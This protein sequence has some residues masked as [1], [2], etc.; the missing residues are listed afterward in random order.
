M[1][2]EAAL[3]S[4]VGGT[5][6]R[7]L[8]TAISGVV[9]NEADKLVSDAF[10]H[11]IEKTDRHQNR[12]LQK[13]ILRSYYYALISICEECL[14]KEKDNK[15][16][17][18]WLKSEKAEI[19]GI[20]KKVAKNEYHFLPIEEIDKIKLLITTEGSISEE[21]NIEKE[22]LVSSA[23]VKDCPPRCYIELVK[24][25]LYQRVCVFFESEIKHNQI[26]NNIFQSQLLT[27]IDIKVT[28]LLEKDIV[29]YLPQFGELLNK[30]DLAMQEIGAIH[31]KVK[32]LQETKNMASDVI[33]EKSGY[34][35]PPE[36]T[37]CSFDFDSSY[38]L[39]D[40]F[41]SEKE[42]SSLERSFDNG[43]RIAAVSGISGSG[44]SFI[45]RTFANRNRS[46]FP[47]VKFLRL[48]R[49]TEEQTLG[50]LV[51]S[52]LHFNEATINKCISGTKREQL[53]IKYAAFNRV[54][55]NILIIISGVNDITETDIEKLLE[56]HAHFIL[57]VNNRVLDSNVADIPVKDLR[58]EDAVSLFKS[59]YELELDD[60]SLKIIINKVGSHTGTIIFMAKLMKFHSIRIGEVKQLFDTAEINRYHIPTDAGAKM[61]SLAQYHRALFAFD[62]LSE[63]EASL[64]LLLSLLPPKSLDIYFL[65]STFSEFDL[66]SV[67]SLSLKGYL[68][69]NKET[70]Q[71][72][73]SPLPIKTFYE[74]EEHPVN[75][76]ESISDSVKGLL[77]Y[78][79]CKEFSEIEERISYVVYL[80]E[81][82][83]LK[84]Y[85]VDAELW[86]KIAQGYQL[87]C[88][89][90][91]AKKYADMASNYQID[92]NV[93]VA[94]I[95]L[96]T[97][98]MVFCFDYQSAVDLLESFIKDTVWEQLSYKEQG[99][100]LYKL[101]FVYSF[102]DSGKCE[103]CFKNS[104]HAFQRAG[105]IVGE[106]VALTQLIIR[107][108]SKKQIA[109]EINQYAKDSHKLLKT[110]PIWHYFG[111]FFRYF[112]KAISGNGNTLFIG[113]INDLV[114][115]VDST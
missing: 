93:K 51:L 75:I 11:I 21:I 67:I 65:K 34:K 43:Y 77:K 104:F 15:L 56:L 18:S 96:K 35:T 46:K 88:F 68:D 20:I 23:L 105:L 48:T 110:E 101:G 37:Q 85:K 94:V 13:A 49:S 69:Y 5:I 91:D 99:E 57:C 32:D 16:I 108:K 58:L 114:N 8:D 24:N 7:I 28:Q 97:E 103:V 90:N 38:R 80:S 92:K 40:G 63:E 98:I 112:F 6:V 100:L 9:G 107:A 60:D 62:K 22:K 14:E 42:I 86:V 73:C 64:L 44:R 2:I 1:I 39:D 79:D 70:A 115:A 19:Q 45:A 31:E 26:I 81:K 87:L 17:V 82:L 84:K 55:T 29:S 10:K 54:A 36:L 106:L 33:N 12:D 66:N 52:A 78:N 102:I 47:I 25:T 71:I 53:D 4:V 61:I 95:L 74:M 83:L 109:Y 41:F 27:N 59:Y 76:I 30:F 89:F 111:Y 113:T 3:T 72:R 50:E